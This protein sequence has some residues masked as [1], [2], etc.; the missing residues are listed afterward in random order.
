MK[1]NHYNATMRSWLLV[2]LMMW[3]PLQLSWAATGSYCA[4]DQDATVQHLGHHA[5]QHQ[6]AEDAAANQSAA[7]TVSPDLD[8]GTCHASCSMVL[9]AMPS[10]GCVQASSVV[11]PRPL[12]WSE[13]LLIDRPDRPRWVSP[14]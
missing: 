7:G 13:S 4:H 1:A 8:C 3:M 6:S 12:P 10:S 9:H 2:V 11:L 14:V 5:H